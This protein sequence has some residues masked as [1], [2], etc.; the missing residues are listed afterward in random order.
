MSEDTQYDGDYYRRSP[1]EDP[2]GPDD[3]SMQG[4]AEKDRVTRGFCFCNVP[5]NFRSW[6]RCH[7]NPN[8]RDSAHGAGFRVV[9]E[10]Q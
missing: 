8:T 10:I 9:V 4:K 1:L 6:N 3:A 5:N 2:K 7:R